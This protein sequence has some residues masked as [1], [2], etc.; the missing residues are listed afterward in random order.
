MTETPPTRT[1]ADRILI[2]ARAEGP[3]GLI[4]DGT[5]TITPEDPEWATWD[6]Y[7]KGQGR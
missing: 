4:G 7:L 1:G 2:P 5:R 3:R 6:D